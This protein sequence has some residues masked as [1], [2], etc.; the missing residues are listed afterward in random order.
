MM[1]LGERFVF[2]SIRAVETLRYGLIVFLA[3]V[4]AMLALEVGKE[5]IALYRPI[6]VWMEVK[7]FD[8]SD[9]RIGTAPTIDYERVF[10]R[11]FTGRYMPTIWSRTRNRLACSNVSNA[12]FYN[13]GRARSVVDLDWFMGMHCALPVGAYTIHPRWEIV[14]NRL[15]VARYYEAPAKDFFIR[16]F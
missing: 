4:G 6:T 3:C 8:I 13:A 15:G 14:V 12:I 1:T 9:G 11:D 7:R 16:A 2:A 10:K 5:L